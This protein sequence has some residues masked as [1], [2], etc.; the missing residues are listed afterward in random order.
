MTIKQARRLY[1]G[2]KVLYKGVLHGIVTGIK[3]DSAICMWQGRESPLE[4]P[5]DQMQ[6]VG[7]DTTRS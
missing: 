5:H 6:D 2:D 4:I 1:V 7:R 3:M